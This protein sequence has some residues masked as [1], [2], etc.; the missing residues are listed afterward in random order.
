MR[1]LLVDDEVDLTTAM[2]AG[3]VAEGWTVDVTHD[4]LSAIAYAASVDYDV[5]VLDLMLPQLNGYR[6]LERL[7]RGGITTPV[8]VLTAKLGDLD[9][10]EA[11]DS[12]ADD[13]LMKPFSF[14]VLVARLRALVRRARGADKL[15]LVA[16]DLELD[17]VARTCRRQGVDIDL[18]PLEF[19]LLETLAREPS[20]PVAKDALLA[21]LWPASSTDPNLV[22][23]RVRALR[24]K[25]DRPFGAD[26][27]RTVRGAGY[28]FVPRGGVDE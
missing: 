27:I 11:L 26:S 24:D 18:T 22:E 15:R 16:G 4:G 3:L 23:A 19:R 2:R 8:L 21:E 6:V 12:G 1:A 25:V 13:Y 7:R 20:V 10:T 14:A 5:I 9:Q 17:L 28:R